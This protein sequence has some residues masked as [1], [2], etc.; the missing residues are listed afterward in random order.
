MS[1]FPTAGK[2]GEPPPGDLPPP[3][4]EAPIDE[5]PAVIPVSRVLAQNDVVALFL[6]DIQ[7]YSTGCTLSLGWVLRRG[8]QRYAE[9]N[10]VMNR[11]FGR[12]HTAYPGEEGTLRLG[13]KLHDGT[14]ATTLGDPSAGGRDPMKEP[15]SPLLRFGG[16][17]GSGGDRFATGSRHL[18]LW[19]LPPTGDITVVSEWQNIGIAETSVTF[20]DLDFTGAA[21]RAHKLWPEQPD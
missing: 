2:A 9:W 20:P 18:W 8:N 10:A 5:I 11:A 7:V 6:T 21:A 1:F 3:W 17:G 13:L 14:K 16:G 15:A 4:A 12:P 19:P